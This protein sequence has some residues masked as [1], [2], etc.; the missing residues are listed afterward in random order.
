MIPGQAL[1]P[2]GWLTALHSAVT[3]AAGAFKIQS[4]QTCRNPAE[5]QPNGKPFS[6]LPEQQWQWHWAGL[7]LHSNAKGWNKL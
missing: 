2:A 5:I 3:G 7:P 1:G 6:V 4:H